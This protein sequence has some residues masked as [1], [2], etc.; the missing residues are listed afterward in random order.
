MCADNTSVQSVTTPRPL[1]TNTL[2]Y[3]CCYNYCTSY[4][5]NTVTLLNSLDTIITLDCFRSFR[6]FTRDVRFFYTLLS[7]ENQLKI[8]GYC[9]KNVEINQLLKSQDEL[10]SP[11]GR[12]VGQLQDFNASV[13]SWWYRMRTADHLKAPNC[14]LKTLTIL[15]SPHH[16]AR[17]LSCL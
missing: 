4:A 15:Q 13:L 1:T 5:M 7:K 10:L 14:G 6:P 16:S 17:L 3:Y 12:H 11:R 9:K 8:V 2:Y